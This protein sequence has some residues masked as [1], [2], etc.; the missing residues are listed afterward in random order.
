MIAH[1]CK[2]LFWN[3][4]LVIR[5]KQALLLWPRCA[6]G[7]NLDPRPTS[8]QPSYPKDLFLEMKDWRHVDTRVWKETFGDTRYLKSRKAPRHPEKM[9]FQYAAGISG[10]WPL[11]SLREWP[12]RHI[13]DGR[14]PFEGKERSL[15]ALQHGYHFSQT[16]G[17]VVLH[18]MIAHLWKRCGAI[19]K[20]LRARAFVEF[21]YDP[22]E[23]FRAVPHDRFGFVPDP[24][25]DLQD[26]R[27]DSTIDH[28]RLRAGCPF[29]PFPVPIDALG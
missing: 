21:G 17:H 6:A 5:P 19:A 24:S 4:D 11:S 15:N 7:M 27:F 26:S 8:N 9:S 10:N 23:Y 3:C 28:C 16:A 12:L 1:L 20:S 29:R 22:D 2:A 25:W 18:P 14:F 13:Y